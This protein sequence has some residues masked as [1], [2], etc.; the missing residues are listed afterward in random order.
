M[1]L[2]VRKLGWIN[3]G[4]PKMS[5]GTETEPNIGTHRHAPWKL[6]AGYEAGLCPSPGLNSTISPGSFH[7]EEGMTENKKQKETI[8][9]PQLM[10]F[11]WS[12]YFSFPRSRKGFSVNPD[13]DPLGNKLWLMQDQ[14]C[15]VPFRSNVCKSVASACAITCIVSVSETLPTFHS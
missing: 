5:G 12:N 7:C 14:H 1:L 3:S 8:T 6:P 9:I 15:P 2:C 13:T 4:I 11:I 10:P